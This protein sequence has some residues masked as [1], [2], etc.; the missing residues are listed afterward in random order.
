[1]DCPNCSSRR[2][3]VNDTRRSHGRVW[4][5]RICRDCAAR[6]TTWEIYDE[7]FR[8]QEIGEQELQRIERKKARIE[9][10]LEQSLA[11]LRRQR[12]GELAAV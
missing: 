12:G 4:R 5:R 11:A 7:S 10:E 6:F 9:Q 2:T 1:M 3:Y 8:R